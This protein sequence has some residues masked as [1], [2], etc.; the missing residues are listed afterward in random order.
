MMMV[1][2]MMT[3]MMMVLMFVT[4]ERTCAELSCSEHADCVTDSEGQAECVCRRGYQGDGQTCSITPSDCQYQLCKIY[5]QIIIF[6]LSLVKIRGYAN[7]E[8]A[9]LRTADDTDISTI[10]DIGPSVV[11]FYEISNTGPFD[12]G[13]VFVRKQ[14]SNSKM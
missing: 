8:T 14:Y 4:E 11:H 10:E 5:L 3:M 12:V 13:N 9:Q 2:M 6:S 1:M 7:P